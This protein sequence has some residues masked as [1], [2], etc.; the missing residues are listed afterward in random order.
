MSEP[1]EVW[2][3]GGRKRTQLK[4]L[5][6]AYQPLV[7]REVD[8]WSGSGLPRVALEAQAKKLLLGAF[9][10]FDASRGAQ[11]QTHV[12]HRLRA[13]DGYVAAHRLDV[14]MPVDRLRLADKAYRSQQQ[15][16]LDLGREPTTEEISRHS[17]IGTTTIGKLTRFSSQLSSAAEAGGF[18]APV[19]EDISH[20]Q[21]VADFLYSDLSPMQQKVFEYSVGHNNK[22]IL[23]PGEIAKKLGVSAARISQLKGQIAKK[24]LGYQQATNFLMS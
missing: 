9:R 6:T 14:R 2:H 20:D 4:P 13:M 11:L 17:G 24:A 23:P 5:M 3:A 16:T 21:I 8:R 18:S 15:L 7:N 19:K 22:E 12:M 1:W 10:T